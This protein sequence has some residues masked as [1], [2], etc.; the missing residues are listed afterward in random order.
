MAK[1]DGKKTLMLLMGAIG[2]GIAAAILSVL[3][4][5]S[6][7]RAILASIKGED[8][9]MAAVVVAN[10]DLPKGQVVQAGLFAVRN[11]PVTY[12]HP[13]TVRPDQIESYYGRIL[14]EN[15]TRGKPLLTNFMNETFPVDFSDLIDKGRRA[16]TIQVDEVQ[17]LAG[18]TRPGN[19]IDIF[20]N[21]PSKIAGYQS[22]SKSGGLPPELKQ[23]ALSAAA[24][25]GVSEQA[26]AAGAEQLESSKTP[27][28]VILPV[29]QNI[30]VLSTGRDTYSE[31]LDEL[32]YPQDRSGF[33]FTSMTIDVSPEQA[34][35][36]KIAEDKGDLIAVLRNRNDTDM[37]NFTGITAY[38]LIANAKEM[39]KQDAI[40]KAAEAAGASIDEN[41][42]WVTKDGA[43]INKEDLKISANGT[44]TASGGKL[45]ASNGISTNKDGQYVDADGNVIPPDQV[46]VNADGSITTKDEVMKAAGYSVNENGDYVDKA[47]NVIKP[48]EVKV[49]A[50]GSVVSNDGKVLDG[51]NVTVNKDGFIIADD[52]T[53]MTADG[54]V[55][56]GV[57]INEKGEVVGSDGK[58]LKDSKLQV[59]ADGTVRDS[60][61]KILDGISGSDYVASS[62]SDTISLAGIPDFVSL[63]IGG[64]S[65]DGVA[66]VATMPVQQL[67][68]KMMQEQ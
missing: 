62:E 17:S 37:A 26:I 2:F 66:K 25:A 10:Q 63:I 8:K 29:L 5:Q 48:D 40:R 46:V 32:H 50:N 11:I 41:G 13:N 42:N 21:I 7:E 68:A 39:Q 34:A 28:D 31:H 57:S 51:P 60:N 44:V 1:N 12:I 35:L 23:A 24:S 54:K 9:E 65:K 52:G 3:Y 61:G 43:V 45:L 18:L 58:V 67:K 16:I 30:R 38:D 36:L 56:N 55:L 20:V 59:A 64:A 6:R 49:L 53:V 22:D 33:N 47:G 15:I 4:L 19:K 14:T 27:A